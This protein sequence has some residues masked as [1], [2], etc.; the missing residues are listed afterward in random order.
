MYT[1]LRKKVKWAWSR[2]PTVRQCSQRSTDPAPSK[3]RTTNWGTPGGGAGWARALGA[4]D[5]GIPGGRVCTGDRGGVT[6]TA[7]RTTAGRT[8]RVASAAS[9]HHARE[10]ALWAFW[11]LGSESLGIIAREG[12]PTRVALLRSRRCGGPGG[13]RTRTRTVPHRSCLPWH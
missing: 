5:G 11:G 12:Y 3:E 9:T 4:A 1:P 7:G 10:S 13:P 2:A 6:K 8:P